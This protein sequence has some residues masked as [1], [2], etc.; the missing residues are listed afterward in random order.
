MTE[1]RALT[2]L[3]F[4][5]AFYVFVF[6]LHIRWPLAKDSPLAANFLSQ[7]AVGMTLFFMLSGYIL[8]HRYD[9]ERLDWRSYFGNRFARIYPVYVAA[10]LV[11]LPSMSLTP[12]TAQDW[13]L[14]AASW[15]ALI[16]ADATAIQAW[17]PPMFKYWNNGASW[18]ISAEAFFYAMFPIL[19][20][21]IA[22]ACTRDKIRWLVAAY[23]LSFLP[24][25][26]YILFD[27]MGP[28]ATYYSVPIYR[29]PEF[30]AGMA[31]FHLGRS[32]RIRTA[33]L[34]VGLVAASAFWVWYLALYGPRFPLY[35][36]H[37]W[38][39]VPVIGLAL[40]TLTRSDSFLARIL[41]VRP[42][43]WAGK[44]S[45]CF[46]SFQVL[47]LFSAVDYR[48]AIIARFPLLKDDVWWTLS[49]F[50]PLMAI[51][52][53]GY[54]LIEEPFRVKVRGWLNRERKLGVD[55]SAASSPR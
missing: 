8:A 3:R 27:P 28:S 30:V 41:S 36:S 34:E 35:V 46:Y 47:I 18:S 20:P 24:A 40:L 45:Y 25:A 32:V 48:D 11:T 10:A 52:A 7:G 54:Y 33:I 50:L 26:M 23:L 17:F 42:A 16:L 13:S 37:N 5:A 38:I 1:I 55:M 9:G 21:I 39:N 49:L 51:S 29:F 14:P 43:V 6:H 53:A 31:A 4:L 44:I 22:K 12:L 2:S 19:T 15:M